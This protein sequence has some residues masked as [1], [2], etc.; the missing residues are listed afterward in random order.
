MQLR[1]RELLSFV[2]AI[3]SAVCGC[4]STN[5]DAN[6]LVG[7]WKM[8]AVSRS[9]FL[10]PSQRSATAAIEL[11]A[12]G[13]FSASAVPADLLYVAREAR[14]SLVTGGGAWK[15]IRSNG[16]ARVQLEFR[17]IDSDGAKRDVPYVTYM[18]VMRDRANI[19]LSYPRGDP[20]EGNWVMFD[21]H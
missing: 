12:D 8:A 10:M 3:A 1:M 15:L 5:V 20:D 18:E 7:A 14:E 21:K 6:E 9:N 11:R 16:S 13:T 19:V 2:L 4:R 17:S